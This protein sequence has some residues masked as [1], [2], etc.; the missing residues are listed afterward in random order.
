MAQHSVD[1]EQGHLLVLEAGEGG[2]GQIEQLQGALLQG[3][4][5]DACNT[6]DDI[7]TTAET[8]QH[9]GP[10]SLPGQQ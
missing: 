8:T 3:L 6:K 2:W 4:A 1:G 7:M 10:L 9:S 5:Q